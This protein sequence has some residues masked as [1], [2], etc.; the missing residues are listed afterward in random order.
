M[1][2]QMEQHQEEEPESQRKDL[3][4]PCARYHHWPPVLQP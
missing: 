2:Q 3:P 1:E 4:M